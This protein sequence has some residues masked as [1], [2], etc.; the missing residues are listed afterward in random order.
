MDIEANSDPNGLQI[1]ENARQ[2]LSERRIACKRVYDLELTLVT[3]NDVFVWCTAQQL[4]TGSAEVILTESQI[5]DE[6][7]FAFEP[8]KEGDY[9]PIVSVIV[10]GKGTPKA[11]KVKYRWA[12]DVWV[13]GEKAELLRQAPERLLFARRNGELVL[14]AAEWY[15]AFRNEE[16]ELYKAEQWA[17]RHRGTRN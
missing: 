7:A 12:T 2:L 14:L 4:G 16:Q 1:S 11:P 9:I 3:L 15:G 10:Q 17:K 6:A 5:L 8:L 13:R